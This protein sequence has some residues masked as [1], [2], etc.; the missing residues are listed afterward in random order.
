MDLI[1]ISFFFFFKEI[2]NDRVAGQISDLILFDFLVDDHDREKI[3][4]WVLDVAGNIVFWDS[5]LAF[6]HGK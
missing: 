3:R 6:S 4:N 5:G 1:I 2:V